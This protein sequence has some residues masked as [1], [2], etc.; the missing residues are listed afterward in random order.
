M[1]SINGVL[2]PFAGATVQTALNAFMAPQPN[3]ERTAPQRRADALTEICQRILRTD[4]PPTNGG[5]RPQL[6][7]RVNLDTLTGSGVEP[8]ELSWGLGPLARTDLARLACD[9]EVIRVVFNDK[10]ELLDVGRAQRTFPVGIR[11]ALLAQWRTC[12]WHGC[13][14][15]AEWAE[16]HH[17]NPWETGGE[18][19]LANALLACAYHHHVIHRDRWQLEKL[20]DG[21]IIARLGPKEMICKPNAP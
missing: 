20:P 10:S 17:I 21:T 1:V 9:A 14:S 7:T 2:E 4:Q 18:T 19:S 13:N 3:D 8:A 11:R 6:L 15:P 5:H 12:F 16:G